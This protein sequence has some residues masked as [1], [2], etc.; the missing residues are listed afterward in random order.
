M[1]PLARLKSPFA[2]VM[3]TV[4][5]KEH[6]QNAVMEEGIRSPALVL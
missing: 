6:V 4:Q 1:T 2:A 3:T 5:Y